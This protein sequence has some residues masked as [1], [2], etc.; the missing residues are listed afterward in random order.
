MDRHALFAPLQQL[1]SDERIRALERIIPPDVVQQVLEQTGHAR[2]N[3]PRLPH[4]FM[5]YFVIALS[6]FR[7]DSS[8]QVFKNLQRFQPGGTPQRNTLTQARKGL[9]VAPLRRLVNQVVRLLATPQT[10]GAFY[11]GM[12][13]MATDGFVLDLPDSP[14]NA[15]IFGKPQSGR[16]EGAFPQAR[17]LALCETGTHAFYRW[18]VKPISTG[19]V[20][21]APYVLRWLEEDMLL[22]WD[23]NFLSYKNLQQVRRRQAHLLARI[24][25][26]LIFEPIEALCD[27]S[28][29]AKMYPSPKHRAADQEGILVRLIEYTLD[30]PGR[31][32]EGKPHRLLT[33]LLDADL[34]PAKELI[35]LYH[36]RWEEELAIDE[37]KTH[38]E[39]GGLLRSQTPAGVVQEIDGLLL[40]HYAVRS[41][42]SQAA[43]PGGLDPRRLSFVGTLKVLRCRLPEVPKDPTDQAGRQRWWQD[44]LAEVAEEVLPPRRSRIN[45]RVIKRKMSKWPKK[46]PHH[47]Q[48]PQPT[49]PF[50]ESIV[51]T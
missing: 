34:D 42:M 25:S 41:L 44:L 17:V 22:L 13:L 50:R 37:V 24:K 20:R 3:C 5:A 2:R 8:R 14:D 39:E 33:T 6:L 51:I 7:K 21:M 12:R 11:R 16:A 45:P 10:P 48:T 9:G 18:M 40:G 26:N 19:E 49:K 23:R 36:Q 46:R 38:Q 15:R 27:G 31:P 43:A 29:L 47:R 30:D 28:Y 35:V 32:H 1:P 4:W